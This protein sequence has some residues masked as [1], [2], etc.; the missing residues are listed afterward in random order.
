MELTGTYTTKSANQPNIKVKV[1]RS[2]TNNE[3]EIVLSQGDSI[4][5]VDNMDNLSGFT[6][7]LQSALKK[8][9][10]EFCPKPIT[11]FSQ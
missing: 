1:G 5:R 3:T 11:E 4:I 10:Q 6:K 7:T 2:D 8:A 9:E